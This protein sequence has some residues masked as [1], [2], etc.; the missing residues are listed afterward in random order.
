MAG[1]RVDLDRLADVVDQIGRFDQQVETA[2][3]D[4]QAQVDRLHGTWSGDAAV[5]HEQAHAKW[6]RGAAEMRA[7]LAVLRDNA[8]IGHGNYTGAVTTN[9]AMWD[10]A[11]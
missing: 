11:R 2:L 7:A 9:T 5:A 1:Y 10:Q 8:R 3:A 4:V 6:T